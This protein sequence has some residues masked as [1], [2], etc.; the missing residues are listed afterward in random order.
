MSGGSAMT[1][2]ASIDA[3]KIS[4]DLFSQLESDDDKTQLDA[5]AK[6]V[7]AVKF[8]GLSVLKIKD[9]TATQKALKDM[10]SVVQKLSESVKNESG[11]ILTI[12]NPVSVKS[13]SIT[14]EEM[15]ISM[16]ARQYMEKDGIKKNSVEKAQSIINTCMEML[17]TRFVFDGDLMYSAIGIPASELEKI[18]KNKKTEGPSI[19]EAPA[20]KTAYARNPVNAFFFQIQLTPLNN[21]AAAFAPDVIKPITGS[22]YPGIY[23]V[24]GIQDKAL[25]MDILMATDE[26]AYYY[27]NYGQMITDYFTANNYS[28]YDDEYYEGD[29]YYDE[30]DYSDGDY[31]Y[32]E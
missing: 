16:D 28:D 21:I 10:M 4:A 26:L 12:A 1:F 6:L 32:E 29:N 30:N 15:K 14:I 23:S 17:T 5:A 31:N 25:N 11:I 18:V 3:S 9:K 8:R 27:S 2:D 24:T 7:S 20:I 19:M 22:Y 13:G